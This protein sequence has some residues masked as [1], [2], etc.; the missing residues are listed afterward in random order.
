[1]LLENSSQQQNDDF[2]LECLFAIIII[3]VFI[4][5]LYKRKKVYKYITEMETY[6][7]LPNF[8][9]YLGLLLLTVVCITFLYK[10]LCKIFS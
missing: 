6:N 9:F 5:C 8:R 7:G 2:I 3:T 1:M 4:L 10:F